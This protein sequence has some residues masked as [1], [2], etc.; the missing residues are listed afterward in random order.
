MIEKEN[1]I[2]KVLNENSVSDGVVE[3]ETK[4]KEN[5]ITEIDI[6]KNDLQKL[7]E[8]NESLKQKV[9]ELEDAY[10]R[11]AADFDNYRKRM[12]AQM[13]GMETEGIKKVIKELLPIIDN[14]E[15]ALNSS[16]ETKDFDSLYNGLNMIYSLSLNLLEKF[17]VK[18]FDSRDQEF[19]HNFH[20]AVMMEEKED[21][22]FDY[23]VLEELEKGYKLGDDVLR[24]AKVKVG[25][26]KKNNKEN[27]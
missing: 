11:K 1:V 2:E 4:A 5:E 26:K 20:E 17:N 24:H 16:K 18:P 9:N 7:K 23:M 10:L 8:E 27:N 3:K 19:D 15:R 14:F 21:L 12:L 13:A 6:L 25:K 22:K